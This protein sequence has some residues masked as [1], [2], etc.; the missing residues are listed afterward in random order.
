MA[1]VAPMAQAMSSLPKATNGIDMLP[2][3][4]ELHVCKGKL[5]TVDVNVL[6]TDKRLLVKGTESLVPFP[7]SICCG[8]FRIESDEGYS[9]V[10]LK[11]V[12][13][14]VFAGCLASCAACMWSWRDGCPFLCCCLPGCLEGGVTMGFSRTNVEYVP[15]WSFWPPWTTG[16]GWS[17]KQI[18]LSLRKKDAEALRRVLMTHPKAFGLGLPK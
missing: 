6:V 13:P 16:A 17:Y 8:C 4:K 14:W 7:M 10:D 1:T 3:E 15:G 18:S 9:I 11:H 5:G 12:K 2:D